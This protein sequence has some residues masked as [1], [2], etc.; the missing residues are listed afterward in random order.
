MNILS[1]D[2]L[3][4]L[5]IKSIFRRRNKS[6]AIRR[7]RHPPRWFIKNHWDAT[8]RT[9]SGAVSNGQT[10]S[11]CSMK[12]HGSANDCHPTPRDARAFSPS[13]ENAPM[14]ARRREQ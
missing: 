13:L 9:A 11:A 12:E 2:Y 1:R 8:R 10:E 5:H 14:Q 7:R 6:S 3:N 4:S